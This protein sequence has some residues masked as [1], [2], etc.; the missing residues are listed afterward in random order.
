MIRVHECVGYI[1]ERGGGH[2]DLMEGL[3]FRP[4]G[5]VAAALAPAAGKE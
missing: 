1:S 2:P 4:V 5:A 3:E